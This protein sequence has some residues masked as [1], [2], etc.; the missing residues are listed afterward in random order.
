MHAAG[1]ALTFRPPGRG[2]RGRRG[3]RPAGGGTGRD[4]A[5]DPLGPFAFAAVVLLLALSWTVVAW[6]GVL[7]AKS[8]PP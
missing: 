2:T 8:L 4:P 5:D 1:Q 7:I 3:G 6:L